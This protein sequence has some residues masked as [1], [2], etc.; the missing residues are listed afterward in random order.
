MYKFIK[1]YVETISGADVYAIISLLIFFIFFVS[2]LWYVKQMDK[3]SINTLSNIP[4]DTD[5]TNHS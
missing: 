5:E 4:F 1:Q 3:N 2:L